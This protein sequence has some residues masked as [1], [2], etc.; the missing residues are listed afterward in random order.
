MTVATEPRAK[1]GRQSDSGSMT[2]SGTGGFFEAILELQ[3]AANRKEEMLRCPT[4]QLARAVRMGPIIESGWTVEKAK[5][6]KPPKAAIGFIREQIEHHY[7]R[8]IQEILLAYD[9][10]FSPFEKIFDTEGRYVV[11]DRLKSL[12]PDMTEIRVDRRTGGF[13]GFRQ[14]DVFLSAAECFNYA[15]E[16]FRQRYRG[17][18]LLRN[19]EFEYSAWKGVMVKTR[20][21]ATKAGGV[22]PI[23]QYP[24]GKSLDANGGE[25]ENYKAARLVMEGLAAGKPVYMPNHLS[26]WAEEFAKKGAKPSELK[27]WMIEMLEAGSHGEDLVLILRHLESQMMRGYLVPERSATEGQSGTKAE[28]GVHTSVALASSEITFRDII[29]HINDYIID[30]LLTLN[31]G[32]EA[33]GTV[34]LVGEALSKEKRE[35]FRKVLDKILTAPSNIDLLPDLIDMEKVMEVAG[36]PSGSFVGW[37]QARPGGIDGAPK[38]KD[39]EEPEA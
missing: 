9:D 18:P 21:Y 17:R 20:M 13:R 2:V 25:I 8:S 14:G 16:G 29:R 23:I 30:Q 11:I 27:A 28:A 24:P 34:K 1:T 15:H 38:D 31:W 35:F 5:N 33:K 22:I 7:P 12:N 26:Q 3:S 36:L 37:G 39:D 4:I 6:K 10:G 32:A 19:V